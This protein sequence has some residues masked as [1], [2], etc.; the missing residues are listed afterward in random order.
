VDDAAVVAVSGAAVATGGG[1]VEPRAQCV[2]RG[3]EVA[4]EAKIGSNRLVEPIGAPG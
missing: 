1:G 2:D 4:G 3:F